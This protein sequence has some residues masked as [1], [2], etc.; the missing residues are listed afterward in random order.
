MIDTDSYVVQRASIES[1][2]HTDYYNPPQ[3]LYVNGVQ[4]AFLKCGS[5]DTSEVYVDKDHIFVVSDR[6]SLGYAGMQI[7]D[8]ETYEEV[9]D[10]FLDGEDYGENGLGDMDMRGILKRLMQWWQ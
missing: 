2:R 5:D 3:A 8:R 9:F 1:I 7:L 4:K 6:P 10:I